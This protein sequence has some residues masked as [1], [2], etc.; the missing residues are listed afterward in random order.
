MACGADG[1]VVLGIL[2]ADDTLRMVPPLETIIEPDDQLV[3]LAERSNGEM[4]AI[5]QL[6]DPIACPTPHTAPLS[7]VMIGWSKVGK[8]TLDRLA[9]Y[10]PSGSRVRILADSTLSTDD[11][12]PWTRSLDRSFVHTKHDPEE[13]LDALERAR[14]DV[15][16]VLGYSDGMSEVEADALTLLT[17]FMLNKQE[18][19]ARI[20]TT[21]IVAQLF[22]SRLH[23]LAEGCADFVLTDA[24]ASRM[25]VHTSRHKRL[26]DV[27]ADLFGADGA[28]VD[29][30]PA[31][32]E[33]D[34][35]RRGRGRHGGTGDG[36]DRDD[37]EWR[38]VRQPTADLRA[39]SS[40]PTTGS[41]SCGAEPLIEAITRFR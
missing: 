21:R 2:G 1:F 32:A 37:Q 19:R 27:Y 33:R 10:L 36:P 15:V 14:A 16:V 25:L 4:P 39:P 20:P 30:D 12:P 6:P 23:D 9:D 18:N 7:V 40:A 38:G 29:V 5:E 34:E 3:V 31:T 24:L 22:D 11:P 17:I 41:S 28:I 26:G 13:I 35:L 8:L